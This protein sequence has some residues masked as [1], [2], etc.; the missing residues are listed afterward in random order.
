MRPQ[1]T[2]LIVD[3]RKGRFNHQG[4]APGHL[5][6]SRKLIDR[7]LP[8]TRRV[9]GQATSSLHQCLNRLNLFL[10]QLLPPQSFS[11][12]FIS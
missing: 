2:D 11:S 9:D 1:M 5:T 10:L 12:I 4:P 8:I 6:K 3:Q 7:R